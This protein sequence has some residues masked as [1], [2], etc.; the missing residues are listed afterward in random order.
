MDGF[1]DMGRRYEFNKM[2]GEFRRSLLRELDYRQEAQNLLTLGANLREFER[3]VVPQP[4]NDYTTSRVLTM[5]YVAGSSLQ[6]WI[7]A[8]LHTESEHKH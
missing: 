4:V 1:T 2:L 5:D 3:I 7:D 8:G 6:D